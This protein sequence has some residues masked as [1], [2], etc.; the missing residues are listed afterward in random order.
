MTKAEIAE[1]K[2]EEI[3]REE[4]VERAEEEIIV[5]Q[6]RILSNKKRL[7]ELRAFK[8]PRTGRAGG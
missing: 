5:L 3:R 6:N 1:I 4:I 7:A 8:V 2:Y